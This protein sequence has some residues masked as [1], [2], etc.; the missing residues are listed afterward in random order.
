M[1]EAEKFYRDQG[2]EIETTADGKVARKDNVSVLF[3]VSAEWQAK[4]D[5]EAIA[6]NEKIEQEAKRELLIQE[7]IRQMAI[8][9]L[10]KKG[11]IRR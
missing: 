11:V 4:A 7:E 6:S 8:E 3:E 10:Q 9:R 1:T 2:Y 5:A